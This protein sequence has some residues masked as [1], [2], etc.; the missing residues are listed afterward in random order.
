MFYIVFELKYYPGQSL[1]LLIKVTISKKLSPLL[2]FLP[3]LNVENGNSGLIQ[4]VE[5]QWPGNGGHCCVV[6]LQEIGYIKGNS[7]KQ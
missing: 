1:T 4:G 6:G 5:A 2:P 3:F 7:S